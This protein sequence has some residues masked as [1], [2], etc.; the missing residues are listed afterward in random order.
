MRKI[1]LLNLCL[2]LLALNIYASDGVRQDIEKVCSFTFPAP[3][4]ITDVLGMKNYWY[5]TDTCSYL[6]QLKPMTNKGVVKDS[7][8][9]YAFYGGVVKGVLRGFS[10]TLIG[11][12][13]VDINGMPGEEVE[14]I[15]G[16]ENH[17]PVSVCTRLLLLGDHLVIYTFSAPYSR[18][19]SL[20]YAQTSFFASFSTDL[21]RL[22]S[23][24][25]KPAATATTVSASAD[26]VST[27]T[28]IFDSVSAQ[29]H[30]VSEHPELVRSNTLHFI[31]SFAACI[32]LLALTL[33]GLVKWKKRHADRQ[34]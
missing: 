14:Y 4:S 17:Q 19:I 27:P 20:K 2:C 10:A 12:K 18:F 34:S 25:A 26:T 6:V 8:S 33:Y 30:P 7:A 21:N 3:P 16:D 15:K 24:S 13:P 22:I 1:V 28:P 31:I 9:L 11:K 29:A 32:S 23:Q 5:H